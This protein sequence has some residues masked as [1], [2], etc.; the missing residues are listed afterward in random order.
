M[1]DLP[2]FFDPFLLSKNEAQLSGALSLDR[3][4]RV[5]DALGLP[6]AG[7][8]DVILVFGHLN[9]RMP[10]ISGKAKG[11]VAGV[12]Q[13]CLGRVDIDIDLALSLGVVT[14]ET[15]L[16]KLPENL[17]PLMVD[18]DDR[19]VDTALMV[20]DEILLGLPMVVSHKPGQCPEEHLQSQYFEKKRNPFA[21]LS[22]LKQK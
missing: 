3:M 11:E 6:Q 1:S 7:G 12:C 21:A 2:V 14:N 9:G 8:V 17:E 19:K 10:V 16:D 18:A 13:L 15:S 20:E 22:G 4:E 5:S